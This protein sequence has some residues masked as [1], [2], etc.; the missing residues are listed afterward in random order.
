MSVYPP[1]EADD[2]LA[3]H[4]RREIEEAAADAAAYRINGMTI[5][6][7]RANEQRRLTG[8]AAVMD[9]GMA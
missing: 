6:E 2:E 1:G 5:S 7:H 9:E 8:I 4:T 3:P